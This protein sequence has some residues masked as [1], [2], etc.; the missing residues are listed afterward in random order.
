MEV[1]FGKKG[2]CCFRE[3]KGGVVFEEKKK[4][5]VVFEEKKRWCC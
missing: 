1:L 5:G 2:R 3:K 4:G